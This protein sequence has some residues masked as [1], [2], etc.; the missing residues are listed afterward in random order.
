VGSN[1]NNNDKKR[2]ASSTNNSLVRKYH[3]PPGMPL[4]A[5]PSIPMSLRPGQTVISVVKRQTVSWKNQE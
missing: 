2:P 1:H 5:P 3:L 4:Q